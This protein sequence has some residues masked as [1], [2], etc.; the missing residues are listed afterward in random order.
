VRARRAIVAVPP[1]LA[2]RIRYEPGLPVARD[3]LTQQAPMG[4]TT[5]VFLLY[6][7]AF[8][9][10]AGYSGEAISTNGPA[11]AFFDN[12]SHD[13]VQPCLLAFIVGKSARDFSGLPEAERRASVVKQAA[14]IF[15]DAAA[16]PT[17]VVE[18]DWQKEPWTRGCPVGNFSPGALAALG[19]A[20]RAPC[21]RIHWAGTETASVWSG[22][23]EGAI[24]SG[25]R[26]A[27]EVS[28]ALELREA[29][30]AAR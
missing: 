19:P 23:M 28:A 4:A 12:S 17:Q 8:W 6:E 2:G 30:A 29:V 7:R 10:D 11:S 16:S 15:G 1:A 20:L 22:Y 9:R 18:Q 26:A 25:E 21:G 5:K 13:L 27:R 3:H 24:E 14:R